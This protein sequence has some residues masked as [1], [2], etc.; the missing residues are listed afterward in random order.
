MRRTI[1]FLALLIGGGLG[2]DLPAGDDKRLE[3]DQVAPTAVE[4]PATPDGIAFFETRIR[5][6]LVEKCYQCHS[7]RAEKLRGNLFL[8]TRAGIRQG[9]DIG[10]AV[11]PG[12]AQNSPL[13]QA[14][15]HTADDL[16]MPPKQKLP[17]AVIADFET[18]VKMGAPDPRDGVANVARGEIDLEKG[19]Q[20]WSFQPPRRVAPPAVKDAAWPRGEI[21]RIVLSGLEAR[22][23]GPVAD[24]DKLTLLR[25]VYH[26]L[27]G[28]PPSPRDIEQFAND[29]SPEAFAKIVDDLLAS[30]QFGVRWGRHW[31]DVA[32]YAESA[33]DQQFNVNFPHAWRYRDYVIA[34]FNSDKP[35]DRFAQEQIAGDLLPAANDREKA[36]G[37]IATAFLALGPKNLSER[38]RL[39]F[40]MDLVDEQIDVV[41]QAFLGLTIACARCHDHKFDPIPSKDYYALAGIFRSTETC[42]GYGAYTLLPNPPSGL[43]RLDSGAGMPR[44]GEAQTPERRAALRQELAETRKRL[45]EMVANRAQYIGAQIERTRLQIAY[46]EGRIDSCEDDG[47]PRPYTMGVRDRARA[48]DCP[49]YVRGEVDKPGDPV[50]RGYVQVLGQ[51]PL[52][53]GSGSG[54]LELAR[55]IASRDNPLTARVMANRVWQHLFGS[56]IVATPDNFGASGPG[57]S[58][59]QLLDNLAV[60]F[61]DDGWSIKRLI[62]R[63]VLSRAYQLGSQFDAR[64]HEVDPD[65]TLIWRMAKKRQ[66]AESLRD[67]ILAISRQLDPAPQIGSIVARAGEEIIIGG[68]RRPLAADPQFAGRSV[69]LPVIRRQLPEVLTLFDF[70]DATVVAGERST[71]TVPAQGLFLLNNAWVI[72]QSRITADLLVAEDQSNAARIKQ[73]YL[74]VFGRPPTDQERQAALEFL[75]TYEQKLTAERAGSASSDWAAWSALCQAWFASAE[76]LYI[77]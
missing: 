46:L 34:A 25:R 50:P 8:D 3:P 58:N 62:R 35:Y 29:V 19:R 39:Q 70:A 45:R 36:E 10:P 30:P 38:N 61:M 59:L 69:Y 20:F 7:V 21:D 65:N 77:N 24:S 52:A 13:I 26:D 16:K 42:Y 11:I 17:D 75:A 5:P 40:T 68:P 60:S 14:I 4:W 76:F 37:K 67:S 73:G 1:A 54:R 22:G 47:E 63:V 43:I 53:I 71:T 74:R 64:N 23:L 55:A 27:I 28:L 9:G 18:W 15:R 49:T 32:R 66:D 51:Q 44:F 31:L 2:R 72:G 41:S 48:A 33:G 12:D 57:P 6:V 56:G